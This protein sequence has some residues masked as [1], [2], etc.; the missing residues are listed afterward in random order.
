M[1]KPVQLIITTAKTEH[2]YK[3]TPFYQ[4]I[5]KYTEIYDYNLFNIAINEKNSQS[6]SSVYNRW[7]IDGFKNTILVF[8]HDDVLIE[9]S[10]LIEKLNIAMETY[11]LVGL[12]GTTG[13]I[14]VKKPVLWHLLADKNT[15]RGAV[16]HFTDK[17]LKSRFMTP[18]GETPSRVMLIDGLFMA[19]NVEKFLDKKIT[20][21]KQNPSYWNFY[22]LDICLAANKAGLKTGVYPIWTTHLSHGLETPTQDWEVGQKWFINKWT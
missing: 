9:D 8:V 5:K 15:W 14:I 21:D 17:T 2:Q 1:I 12:A 6:L 4:A 10:H 20:F 19:I 22:D 7:L 13:P 11:D 16:A 3:Q 18:F